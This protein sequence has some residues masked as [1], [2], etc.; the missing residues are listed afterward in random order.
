MAARTVPPPARTPPAGGDRHEAAL[1][2]LLDR[3]EA[4]RRELERG[5]AASERAA[6]L[7][8]AAGMAAA[9]GRQAAA[10]D[11]LRSV[12]VDRTRLLTETGAASLAD[13][14]ARGGLAECGRR[15]E[16]LRKSLTSDRAGSWAKYVSAKRSAD[17]FREVL[18]LIARG[19]RAAATYGPGARP[20][21]GSLL[22][23]SG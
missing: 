14:A 22:N 16:R 8:D 15:I 18:D 23:L 4:A 3:L 12:A 6:R 17:S 11:A 20:A 13:L 1:R 9:A 21:G 19:G 2:G 5:G 10:A 7:A